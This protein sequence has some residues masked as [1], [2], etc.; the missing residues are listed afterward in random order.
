MDIFHIEYQLHRSR[1]VEGAGRNTFTHLKV[2]LADPLYVDSDSLN[3][4]FK[5]P[6]TEFHR[7]RA[8]QFSRWYYK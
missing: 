6:R 2:W 4:F 7:N 8:K 1:R 5:I 3:K